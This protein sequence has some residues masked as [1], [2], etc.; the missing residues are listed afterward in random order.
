MYI[1]TYFVLQL[2]FSPMCVTFCYAAC[3]VQ[4]IG[5]EVPCVVHRVCEE[6]NPLVNWDFVRGPLVN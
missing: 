1:H 6:G 5:F 2:V 4:Y 3:S